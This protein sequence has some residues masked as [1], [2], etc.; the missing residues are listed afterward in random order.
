[1]R[2]SQASGT[3]RLYECV[4]PQAPELRNCANA[5]FLS[6]ENAA[7]P[8]ERR[9]C[10]NASFLSPG[11]RRRGGAPRGCTNAWF[12]GPGKAAVVRVR[13]SRGTR[14]QAFGR[15]VALSLDPPIHRRRLGA[16]AHHLAARLLRSSLTHSPNAR[17]P[18]LGAGPR[19]GAPGPQFARRESVNPG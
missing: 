3:P 11:E 13:A 2:G 1:M 19:S 18:V 10:T 4:V 14:N 15:C 6:P 5:W 16:Q 7:G 9:G 8:G 17:A 12:L